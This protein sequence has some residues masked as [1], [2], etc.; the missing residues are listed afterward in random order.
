MTAASTDLDLNQAPSFDQV[1]G[2]AHVVSASWAFGNSGTRFKVFKLPG[3]ARNVW[4]KLDDAA[5]VHRVT[6]FAPR[7]STILPWDKVDDLS[8]LKSGLEERGLSAGPVRTNLF[9][10]DD[11]M[12]G[13]LSHADRRVRQKAIAHI[14]ECIEVAKAVGSDTVGIWLPDGTNYPGQDSLMARKRRLEDSLDEVYALYPDDIRLV[15][16]YK[17][18]EPAFYWTDVSDWGTALMHCLRL[19]ERAS[20]L[21]D[22]GHHA[23]YTNIEGIVAQLLDVDRL[24]G[25]DLNNRAYADD[26]LMVGSVDPFQLFRIM[27][28]LVSRWDRAKRV[29]LALDQ[30]HNIEPKVPA[31]VRSVLNVQEALAKATLVDRAALQAA[32]DREDVLGGYEVLLDAYNTDVRPALAE[33]RTA[34]GLPEDPLEELRASKFMERVV[35]ARGVDGDEGW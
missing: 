22:L 27:D 24:G 12:L 7:I 19:G 17:F 10:D 5:E 6:G 31:V 2:E 13:T 23:A 32:W 4:E 28:Q 30:N 1:M 3:C 34:R 18:F 20:V 33:W 14:A 35:E 16:E 25:F 21:V 8:E 9:Q 11:Y 26:D 29:T 15:L